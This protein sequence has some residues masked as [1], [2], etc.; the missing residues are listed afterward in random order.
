MKKLIP[1]QEQRD[2]IDAAKTGQDVI[3]QALAGSS[4][5]TTCVMI[6][7]E[8]FKSSLY[9]TF[10]RRMREEAEEKMPPHVD[11]RT[12]HSIAFGKAG[13]P[14]AHKL[15]RPKGRYQ[16]V[17]GTGTEIANHFK[18][19]SIFHENR[20][21][22]ANAIGLAVKE[23]LAK[24]EYSK[25]VSLENKHVSYS[26]LR[27]FVVG[28]K[29]PF[30]LYNSFKRVVLETAK[31]LWK[32]RVDV[33][34]NIVITHDTYLKVFQLSG[35]SLGEY[36][37]V[38][39][40]ESQDSSL[41]MVDVLRKQDCQK[42]I[43]GDAFQKI[44]GWRGSVDAMQMFN[45]VELKLTKSFRFGE[46]VAK[47]ASAIIDRDLRGNEEVKSFVHSA[48]EFELVGSTILYR[49]NSALLRD[50]CS[51]IQQ[52]YKVNLEIDTY[53]FTRL[54]ESVVALKNNNKRGVKHESVM[55]YNDWKELVE[56]V[57]NGW[58][59]E[60]SHV[61]S[62]VD[63]GQEQR[64]L[65]TLK[66]HANCD[67]PEIV[68]TT[69]HKAKGREFSVVALADDFPS[70]YD[71]DNSW[72]G[73]EEEERNLLYVAA[74]RA[75]HYLFYNETVAEVF[76]RSRV[77]RDSGHILEYDELPFAGCYGVHGYQVEEGSEDFF[78]DDGWDYATEIK[79]RAFNPADKPEEFETPNGE[80]AGYSV[81]EV[82]Q[83]E[84][85]RE[86]TEEVGAFEE[87]HSPKSL[88]QSLDA[89]MNRLR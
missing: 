22:S 35:E 65:N 74:T 47:V 36:D 40:D 32:L 64:I 78:T 71:S 76:N 82:L 68:M 48:E 7:Q 20:F 70:G 16:N 11:V 18:L 24:Y 55:P 29:L 43:V 8:T 41:V 6:A 14:L 59:A 49:T 86:G 57:K 89:L 88:D 17:C 62:L 23:T 44:Y 5:T 60:V 33:N 73:L 28:G 25:E 56:D 50:A 72:V 77:N 2:I 58:G 37:I 42:I 87:L 13:I 69:A 4:K 10:N 79:V 81:A 19:K 51:Y 80:Q 85:D 34:S 54:L 83:A 21:V 66:S 31:K 63:K 26:V 1:T 3:V 9:L 52:G 27:K 45:G 53:D 67:N 12:W 30:E 15:K 39:S 61:V 46:N 75:K 38:Y 84:F